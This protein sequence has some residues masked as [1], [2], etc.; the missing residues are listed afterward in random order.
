M[1]IPVDFQVEAGLQNVYGQSML[2]HCNHYNRYLQQTIE[3]PDYIDSEKIFLQSAAETVYLQLS[4][5]FA[6]HP[7]WSLAEKLQHAAEIYQ[8]AGFGLL[9]FSEFAA[10]GGSITAPSSHYGLAVKLNLTQRQK[11]A[12]YFDKGFIAGV[13]EA[14]KTDLSPALQAGFQL[15]QQEA[16]S[17]GDDFSRY[18]VVAGQP[19]YPWLENL[20]P[21]SLPDFVAVPAR[22]F[23]ETPVDEAGIVQ[24]VAGLPLVGDEEG[25]ISAFGLYLTR[26]YADY[27]NKTSFRFEQALKEAMGGVEL[28]TE[29]L[30]ESGHICAFNTFGGIMKSPEWKALIQPHLRD[31]AD[32]VHGMVAVANALGW[33]I[34]RVHELVPGEKLVMRIY[35]DYESLGYLRWFGKADHPISYLAT[36]GCAGLMNL[37]YY[38]DI[39]QGP[40]LTKELY[41]QLFQEG[42]YFVGQQTRCLAMGDDYTEIVVTRNTAA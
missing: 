13:L 7:Q 40:E 29:L 19:A 15:Q 28:A 33:G 35:Q 39:T 24:A 5:A 17:L 31:H 2:F 22:R 4:E 26:M 30:V 23:T 21:Q 41:V 34:W 10:E 25:L 32:W 12:E 9:D 3:D 8:F 42:N 27:Y 38:G 14:I 6:Q 18:Q 16:I 20:Q 37:I 11:P 1:S 36:G